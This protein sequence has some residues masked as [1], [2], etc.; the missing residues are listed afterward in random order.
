MLKNVFAPSLLLVKSILTYTSVSISRTDCYTIILAWQTIRS[1]YL[2][3]FCER[4]IKKI[5]LKSSLW[6]ASDS[7]PN[8]E[9]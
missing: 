1:V 4:N 5:L 3:Q 9:N 2:L 8:V 6:M 7:K